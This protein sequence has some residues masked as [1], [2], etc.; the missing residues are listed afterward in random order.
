MGYIN[1]HSHYYTLLDFQ[2]TKT[3]LQTFMKYCLT[4]GHKQLFENNLLFIKKPSLTFSY[5]LKHWKAKEIKKNLI[6]NI[7]E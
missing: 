4:F 5:F 3:M 2:I 1:D 6:V 7:Y